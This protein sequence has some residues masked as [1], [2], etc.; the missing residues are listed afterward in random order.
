MV[1]RQL[2]ALAESVLPNG[3]ENPSN[4]EVSIYSN[5][6]DGFFHLN[7]STPESFHIR[8][9]NVFGKIVLEDRIFESDSF[10]FNLCDMSDGLY[11]IELNMAD[12]DLRRVFNVIKYSK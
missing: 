12:L 6:A 5:P 1:N 9:F 10:T 11:L 4:V 2:Y 8:V 7:L 3:I